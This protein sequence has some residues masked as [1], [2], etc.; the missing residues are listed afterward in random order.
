[1][2]RSGSGWH[3]LPGPEHRSVRAVAA[4]IDSLPGKGRSLVAVDG[5]DGVGKSTFG[6]RLALAVDRP[7]VRASCDDFHHPRAHRNRRGPESPE[8]F[9]LD[10]FDY[11]TLTRQLLEPFAA[12]NSFRRRVFDHITDLPVAA[13]VE[14]ARANAVLVLDGVFL[15]REQLRGWW[16][17]SVLLDAPPDVAAA[18]LRRRDGVPARQRY[19]GRHAL[20]FADADPRRHATHVVSW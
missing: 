1:M 9:Y 6:D 13:E 15:H 16:D 12:G 11:D 8:G 14:E 7:V 3:E 2:T 5:V 4:A 19:V 10:S 17:L 20:Y 18:R